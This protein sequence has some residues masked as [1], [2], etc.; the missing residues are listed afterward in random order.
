MLQGPAEVAIEQVIGIQWS[1]IELAEDEAETLVLVTEYE[2]LLLLKLPVSVEFGE[3]AWLNPYS[4]S[5]TLSLRADK[6][7]PPFPNQREST[8]W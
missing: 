3:Q 2:A 6:L 8:T 5:R 4:P 7:K 1:A